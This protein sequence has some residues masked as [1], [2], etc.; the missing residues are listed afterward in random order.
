MSWV[1][2]ITCLCSDSAAKFIAPAVAV[3]A[4]TLI[5]PTRPERTGPYLKGIAITADIPC[6]GCLRRRC[7]H[8]T[9]MEMIAPADVVQ[10]AKDMLAKGSV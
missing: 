9:C 5:G 8:A 10:A 4:I 1:K 7:R 6:Q 2:T 3:E